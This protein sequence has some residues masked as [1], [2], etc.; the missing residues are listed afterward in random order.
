MKRAVRCAADVRPAPGHFELAAGPRREPY[1]A[2]VGGIER[3][4]DPLEGIRIFR[5]VDYSCVDFELQR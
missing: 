5:R 1:V 3:S 2:A 4:G